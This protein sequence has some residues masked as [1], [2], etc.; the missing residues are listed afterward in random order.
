MCK[1]MTEKHQMHF[2]FSLFEQF[3]KS[4]HGVDTW[5]FQIVTDHKKRE[6]LLEKSKSFHHHEVAIDYIRNDAD[7]IIEND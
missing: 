3:E 5:H 2:D 7:N 4:D 1:D 6:H